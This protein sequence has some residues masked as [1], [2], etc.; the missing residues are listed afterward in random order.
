M[1][2]ELRDPRRLSRLDLGVERLDYHLAEALAGAHDICRVDRLIGT[3]EDEALAAVD[4]CGVSGLIRADGVV[5]D[6]L[7]G[8]VLHERDV[9][10]RRGVIDDL[11]AV[12]G[13]YLKHPSAVAD[14][15]DE[16]LELEI[17]IIMLEF[18]LERVSVVLVDVENDELFRA[19]SGDLTAEL[20]PD[21]SAAAGD[22]D[23]LAV[24]E[25]EDFLHVS[26]DRLSAEQV[27]DGDL[28][29]GADGDLTGEKL[30]H[31]GELLQLAS[32]LLADIDDIALVLRVGGRDGD[33]NLRDLI[34]PDARED[35]VSAARDRDAF[36]ISV[37][38]IA[39]VVD[40][41]DDL[42]VQLDGRLDVAEDLLSRL[43]GADDHDSAGRFFG[44]FERRSDEEQEPEREARRDEEDELEQHTA[45]V[46]RGGHIA[47]DDR[48]EEH[49]EE[50]RDDGAE[51]RFHELAERGEAPHTA[52]HSEKGEDDDRDGG[53]RRDY[54]EITVKVIL[55]DGGIPEVEA[56]HQR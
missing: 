15:A 45:E 48:D 7:A 12:F 41:A 10:M 55:R 26:L 32:G 30:I 38:L 17:G 13:E 44:L 5:L 9:L 50:R 8:A 49:M 46:I 23:D 22:E 47:E 51:R 27:F 56:Y 31:T 36:D 4:H 37:P 24:D 20:G 33:I 1:G 53:V 42:V 35:V 28:A 34:L 39:V 25:V 14:G 19:V 54:V 43:S 16:D 52:V 2:E 18:E 21:G 11:R 6:R 40:E 3:D 29:E